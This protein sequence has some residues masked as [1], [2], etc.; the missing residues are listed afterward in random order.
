M[1][2]E[3]RKKLKAFLPVKTLKEN[4]PDGAR[5]R[6]EKEVLSLSYVVIVLSSLFFPRA[7]GE[8]FFP[9]NC[10]CQI[11]VTLALK[12]TL[13]ILCFFLSVTAPYGRAL[14]VGQ[15]D[16]PPL[17]FRSVFYSLTL[18]FLPRGGTF[19]EGF[20]AVKNSLRCVTFVC[21]SSMCN[22]AV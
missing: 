1:D 3:R 5:N 6:S 21:A 8:Y 4:T 16:S 15:T 14:P 7:R 17:I 11:D 22:S 12:L 10:C 18:Q 9:A 19:R 13:P 2:Q 20:F